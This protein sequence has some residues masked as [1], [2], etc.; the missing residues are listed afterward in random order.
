MA[1]PGYHAVRGVA[2]RTGHRAKE[3]N[4]GPGT[5]EMPEDLQDRF[6]SLPGTVCIG[7]HDATLLMPC[8]SL[9]RPHD[10]APLPVT[11]LH[12][13]DAGLAQRARSIEV[14]CWLPC[15]GSAG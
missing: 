1:P 7:Q 2:P 13:L 4:Q 3:R 11:P 5:R 9:D 14:D 10:Q 6:G 8:G 15:H 12:P